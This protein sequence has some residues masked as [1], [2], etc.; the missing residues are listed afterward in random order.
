MDRR[1]WRDKLSLCAALGVL[2]ADRVPGLIE[3]NKR[4][5]K[6]AHD[7]TADVDQSDTTRLLERGPNEWREGVSRVRDTAGSDE[8]RAAGGVRVGDEVLTSLQ[9]WFLVV[10]FELEHRVATKIYDN[11]HQ[12]QIYQAM[13][14]QLADE[15]FGKTTTRIE[16]ERKVGMPPRPRVGDAFRRPEERQSGEVEGDEAE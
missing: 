1:G 15:K 12:V 10:L 8:E 3:L 5:N 6:L 9:S 7:L 14:E 2:D 13:I 11:K 16:A 4:R